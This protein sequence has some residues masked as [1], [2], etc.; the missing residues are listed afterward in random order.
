[1]LWFVLLRGLVSYQKASLWVLLQ[2]HF[3]LLGRDSAGGLQVVGAVVQAFA[4]LGSLFM[5]FLVN[6]GHAFPNS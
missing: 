2:G 6:V 3:Q 4:L 1:M 5:F